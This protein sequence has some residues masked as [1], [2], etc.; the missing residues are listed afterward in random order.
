MPLIFITTHGVLHFTDIGFSQMQAALILSLV[1][2]GG[3]LIRLPIGW[4]G[5]QIEPRKLITIALSMMLFNV[6]RTL[7]VVP[8][9]PDNCRRYIIFGLSYGTMVVM[10]P[11]IVANYFGPDVFAGIN[12]AIAPFTII[13]AACVPTLSGYI[14]EKTS[15][16]DWPFIILL[17]VMTL[18]LIASFFL[19]PPR[20]PLHLKKL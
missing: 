12:A 20:K 8:F 2:L 9:Q 14:F 17:I 16:Y 10:H 18:A 11:T 19:L 13:F 6:N 5:D 7:A 3:G 1:I 4:V 15:S